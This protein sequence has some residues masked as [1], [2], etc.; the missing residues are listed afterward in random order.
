MER[1]SGRK[2]P[3]SPGVPKSKGLTNGEGEKGK[4]R[5]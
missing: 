4:M 2:G 1:L 3:G 5:K